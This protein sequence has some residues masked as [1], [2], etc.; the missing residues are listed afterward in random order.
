MTLLWISLIAWLL[1]GI[2][3]VI[4]IV[5]EEGQLRVDDFVGIFLILLGPILLTIVIN[6]KYGT[7]V[8]WQK[9]SDEPKKG[10][11]NELT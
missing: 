9:Q 7:M 2:A 3:S 6:V 4:W 10:G 8:I 5:W 11:V 1:A